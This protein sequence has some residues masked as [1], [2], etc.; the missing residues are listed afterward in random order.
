MFNKTRLTKPLSTSLLLIMIQISGLFGQNQNINRIPVVAGQFYPASSEALRTSLSDLF[1]S[2]RM[3]QNEN[4]VRAL[5]VPHAGYEFSGQIAAEGYR[6]LADL[7]QYDNIFILASS[8]RVSLGKASVYTAG[9]YISPLGEVKVNQ[10][11]AKELTGNDCISFVPAA[12]S[13]EHSIEVQLPFLQF[14]GKVPPIVPIVIAS[15]VPSV[16]EDIAKALK[17]WFTANNLFIVSADFS[18]YPKYEDAVRLDGLTADAFC[19]GD[20]EKFLDILQKNEE[21]NIRGLS[22]SMCAWPA[23]LVLLHLTAEENG[24]SFEKLK[25][26]NSG[27]HKLYGDKKRVVGYHAIA[28]RGQ[29]PSVDLYL[30]NYNKLK[31]L[32]LSRSCLHE[33]IFNKTKLTPQTGLYTGELAQIAGAFVSLKSDGNLRGCIGSFNTT[34][35]LYKLIPELTI[36]SATRD[37]RFVP[38]R[39][40]EVKNLSIEISVLSP[41][42]RIRNIDKIELGKHGIYIKKGNNNGTFLPQVA[43]ET[44]WTLDEFLGHCSQDKAGIGYNGWKDAELYIYEA[45]VFKELK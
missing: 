3:S 40:G 8:H 14:F 20:P 32:E 19:S 33:L 11:I 45:I 24:L 2:A 35:P 30:S 25:Y 10:D 26:S 16:A 43:V 44:G 22:T 31:I 17:P 41:M 23:A 7:E 29:K 42:K 13:E 12:H 28:L 21:K 39:S 4:P 36:A 27:D 5:L 9:N 38:V 37:T 6:Q 1:S 18:H 15:H 34:K